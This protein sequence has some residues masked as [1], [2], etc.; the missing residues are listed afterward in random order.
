MRVTRKE[1]Q[2]KAGLCKYSS[3]NA[4]WEHDV[5]KHKPWVRV[6]C[7]GTW[8]WLK[9]SLSNRVAFR[10]ASIL[11][12]NAA[13]PPR[14]KRFRRC[15][16]PRTGLS[17]PLTS[18]DGTQSGFHLQEGFKGWF[19]H[20]MQFTSSNQPTHFIDLRK[21]RLLGLLRSNFHDAALVAPNA[22]PAAVRACDKA[23][24]LVFTVLN[25]QW[26]SCHNSIENSDNNCAIIGSKT[27]VEVYKKSKRS[28]FCLAVVGGPGSGRLPPWCFSPYYL[29][30]R[31]LPRL[32]RNRT[33]PVQNLL[34][35][36]AYFM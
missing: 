30:H 12:V 14:S 29:G 21:D 1:G 5:I 3:G 10:R 28:D 8:V 16:R 25:L 33:S 24:G 19:R 7:H 2:R 9:L 32:D 34:S 20:S 22:R 15:N 35:N 11:P 36:P 31:R 27:F 18:W 13:A 4:H 26:K 17:S 6:H 23:I